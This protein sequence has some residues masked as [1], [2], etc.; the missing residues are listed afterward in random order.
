MI[1]SSLLLLDR[2]ECSLGTHNCDSN[3]ACTN[4]AGSFTCACNVGYTGAGTT[5]TGMSFLRL[6]LCCWIWTKFKVTHTF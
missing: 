5:C 6:L 2:D 4:T 3:A 1:P